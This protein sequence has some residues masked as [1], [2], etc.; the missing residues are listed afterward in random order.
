MYLTDRTQV[1]NVDPTDFIH[2]VN[3]ASTVTNPAGDSFK[4]QIS[5]IFNLTSNCCLTG[6]TYL[7][8]VLSFQNQSGS[9]AFSVPGLAFTG[10]SGNCITDLYVTNVYPCTNNIVVQPQSQGKVFFGA[11]SGASGFTVDLVTESSASSTRLGLNTNTPQYTFDF[12]SYDRRS[13]FYYDDKGTEHPSLQKIVFSG[14]SSLALAMGP[15]SD[16]GSTG[17]NISVRGGTSTYG[18]IGD[19]G[20]TCLYSTTNAK[21]LNI[22]SQTP[23]LAFPQQ[24]D[25]IRFYAGTSVSGASY[26]PHIHIQGTGTTRGFMG[27]GQGNVNPTSL[28]DISGS[29]GYSQLRLRISYTP[30][31]TADSNG[32]IG[33]ICWG[34][35]YIYVKTSAGWKRTTIGGTWG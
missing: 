17:L 14:L 5:Q 1:A 26:Q 21:G 16:G 24:P 34:A 7:N 2:I 32:N 11:L 33:D 31:S 9:N 28:V 13:R 20:E 22:I 29:T 8:G 27:I 19:F 15:F 23:E 18:K 6:G 4:A 25:Y 3:T 30:T 10:G 35:D 12:I